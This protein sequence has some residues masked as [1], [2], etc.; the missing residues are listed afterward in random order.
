M[1][2]RRFLQA[3]GLALAALAA[4]PFDTLAAAGGSSSYKS[5]RPTPD[6]RHFTSKAVEA[7]IAGTKSKIPT[8]P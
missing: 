2:R 1:S 4:H 6:K 8:C 7:V 3:G 5:L